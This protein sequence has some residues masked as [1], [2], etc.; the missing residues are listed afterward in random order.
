M[1][2]AVLVGSVAD[3]DPAVGW[4][5]VAE[6]DGRRWGFHCTQ[7]ADGSRVIDVGAPVTFELVSG[8]RGAWEAAR[9]RPA[10]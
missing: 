7:I 8:H 1:A 6:A 9:L 5:T 4:G 3:F 2:P 10:R